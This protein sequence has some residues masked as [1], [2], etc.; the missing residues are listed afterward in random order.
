MSI[1][2]LTLKAWCNCKYKVNLNKVSHDTYVNAM[3][4]FEY[5]H[6]Y[7][8]SISIAEVFPFILYEIKINASLITIP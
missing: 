3:L 4:V 1:S 2:Y 8:S 7:S 5:Y 6:A